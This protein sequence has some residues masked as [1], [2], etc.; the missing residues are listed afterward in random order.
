M[1]KK[2]EDMSNKW[3]IGKYMIDFETNQ[4]ISVLHNGQIFYIFIHYF[5]QSVSYMCPHLSLMHSAPRV[6]SSWQ[7]EHCSVIMQHTLYSP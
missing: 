3:E 6:S 7:I 2:Y 4:I 1:D 5:R